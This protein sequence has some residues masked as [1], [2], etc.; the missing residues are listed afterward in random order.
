MVTLHLPLGN[1]GIFLQAHYDVRV[2]VIKTSLNQVTI[3]GRFW[4][5]VLE[6][7]CTIDAN[8]FLE[9]IFSSVSVKN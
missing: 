5:E 3:F 8:Y 2:K 6:I 9:N 4:L 7:S 1:I